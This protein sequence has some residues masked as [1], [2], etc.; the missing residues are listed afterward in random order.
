MDQTHICYLELNKN[1]LFRSSKTNISCQYFISAD[2]FSGVALLQ[3]FFVCMS[4]IVV[5]LLSII[6]LFSFL[7]RLVP[8]LTIPF[9]G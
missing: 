6:E 5:V 9:P 2:I 7:L 8:W 3:F 1:K 4:L